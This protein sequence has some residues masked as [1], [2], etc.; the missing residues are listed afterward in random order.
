MEP[1]LPRKHFISIANSNQFGKQ[2][3]HCTQGKALRWPAWILWLWTAW[4]G[5]KC[6]MQLWNRFGLVRLEPAS[7]KLRKGSIQYIQAKKIEIKILLR[8]L[9]IDGDPAATSLHFSIDIAE[10]H[11]VY[12]SLNFSATCISRQLLFSF[13]SLSKIVLHHAFPRRKMKIKCCP[14][15]GFRVFVDDGQADYI[16]VWFLK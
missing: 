10:K 5:W 16:T 13:T 2:F 11:S 12:Y 6:C 1:T 4:A 15:S 7:G 3:Y 14:L 8:P 9:H